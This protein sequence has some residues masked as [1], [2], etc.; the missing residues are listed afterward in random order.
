LLISLI[1]ATINRVEEVGTFLESLKNQTYK[2]FELILVD[3]NNDDR[4]MSFI[5]KYSQMY[6]IIYVKSDCAGLSKNRN[7]GLNY[8]NGDI[9]AFPDDDCE[10]KNDTLE[11]VQDFLSNNKYDYFTFAYEDKISKRRGLKKKKKEIHYNNVFESAVSITIFAKR[12]CF[13]GF[14]FDELLGAGAPFGSSEES[15]MLFYFLS[16]KKIGYYNG[17]YTIYHPIDNESFNYLRSYNYGLGFG[18]LHKK[19]IIQY[20]RYYYLLRFIFKVMVNIAAIIISPHKKYYYSGL[21]GKISG[22]I[23]YNK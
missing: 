9:I 6:K 12:D 3:Q 17:F 20:K 4:L 15:D 5:K 19:I 14:S 2:E 11:S 21:K 23:K 13:T 18:A 1:M 8:T 16:N 22:F 10:Y 7:I